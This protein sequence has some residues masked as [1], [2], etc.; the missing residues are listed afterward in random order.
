MIYAADP[1]TAVCWC[2]LLIGALPSLLQ[3]YPQVKSLLR[4]LGVGAL[5]APSKM[6]TGIDAAKGYV[7]VLFVYCDPHNAGEAWDDSLGLSFKLPV[8]EDS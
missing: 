1:D 8:R 4:V 3:C 2:L 6:L 5:T 7:H